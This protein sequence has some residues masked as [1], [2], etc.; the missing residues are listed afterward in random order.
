MLDRPDQL[1][2]SA[3]LPHGVLAI[4]RLPSLLAIAAA[5]ALGPHAGAAP[6]TTR[7][8]VGDPAPP[9]A[10]AHW[11]KGTPVESFEAGNVYVLEFWATWC[12]PCIAHMEHLSELQEKYAD[13]KVTVIGLTDDTL[14]KTISFLFSTYGPEKKIQ[15]DRTRY[16]LAADPDRSVYRE[17]MDA[18]W[19]RSIPTAFI[20]GK[21]ARIEWI[22]H[23]KD[24]DDA[25]EATVEDRWDRSAHRA[26]QEAAARRERALDEAIARLNAALDEKRWEDAIA[27]LDEFIA[28]GRETYA[29]T[30]LAVILTRVGDTR[31]ARAYAR[32]LI[33]AAWD[34][35]PWILEC[36]ARL[37]T[38]GLGTGAGRRV[39]TPDP[40]SRDPKLALEALARAN[41]LTEWSEY[42][43]LDSLAAVE[44]ELRRFEEAAAHQRRA[45]AALE[46]V[47]ERVRD[48]EREEY[49][50][51]LAQY[52]AR[53]AT[54]ERQGR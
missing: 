8:G 40:A 52:K 45:V 33:K 2:R 42:D 24:M 34:D 9:F 32:K 49:G 29:P 39:Y 11:L 21:D 31:R 37:Y 46:A 43:Y 36:V 25:L 15:N 53:L 26:E 30:R 54:Y 23:P 7:L 4:L 5:A 20:I 1:R 16:T 12:A 18:A 41:E 22:G 44:F 47:G 13:R 27:V 17:Y 50:E 48:H 35:D 38:V 10:I 3:S 51:E 6:P 28:Q 14:Q 19:L